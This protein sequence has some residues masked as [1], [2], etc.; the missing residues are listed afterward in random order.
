MAIPLLATSFALEALI[1]AVVA[2]K[3]ASV[4]E[5]GEKVEGDGGSEGTSPDR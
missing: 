2:R 3:D 1:L 5:T 4:L